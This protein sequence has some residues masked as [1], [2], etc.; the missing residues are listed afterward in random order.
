MR[1]RSS[2]RQSLLD[3]QGSFRKVLY[4]GEIPQSVPVGERTSG[5]GRPCA[6]LSQL[7]KR[8]GVR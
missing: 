2:W 4:Y 6:A 3:S 7:D 5:T 8:R 1:G